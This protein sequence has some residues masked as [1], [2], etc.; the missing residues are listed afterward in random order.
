MVMSAEEREGE[1]RE[2]AEAE[3][4]EGRARGWESSGGIRGRRVTMRAGDRGEV[5]GSRSGSQ[6]KKRRR[7]EGKSE[8][9]PGRRLRYTGVVEDMRNRASSVVISELEKRVQGWRNEGDGSGE[10]FERG[11][12]GGVT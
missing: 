9:S 12:G 2:H 4:A 5:R 7:E 3:Q 8:P 6:G 11:E 10:R 1:G